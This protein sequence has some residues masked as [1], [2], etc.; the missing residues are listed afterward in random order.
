M[1]C[2]ALLQTPR[3]PL[4]V[5]EVP[6]GTTCNQLGFFAPKNETTAGTHEFAAKQTEG[7]SRGCL[8]L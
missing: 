3:A 8:A 2:V 5:K 1:I 7:H 6:A 4:D